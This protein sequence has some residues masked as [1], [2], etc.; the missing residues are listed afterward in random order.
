VRAKAAIHAQ[1]PQLRADFV[2]LLDAKVDREPEERM[3]PRKPARSRLS[4]LSPL[5][6]RMNPSSC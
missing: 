3:P 4:A 5:S 6:S 2:G 1:R